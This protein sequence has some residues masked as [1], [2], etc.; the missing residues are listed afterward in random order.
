MRVPGTKEST[1][2]M[3][4][5]ELEECRRS[6]IPFRKILALFLIIVLLATTLLV[7][8]LPD[9][10]SVQTAV[11]KTGI[12]APLTWLAL[13]VISTQFPFPRTVWTVSAGL[14]FGTVLGSALAISGLVVSAAF[15]VL[16]VR[17]LG[18]RT[19]R[20]TSDP[21]MHATL[22][23]I[24]TLLAQRGWVSVLGLRMIPAI[25]FFLVNYACAMTRI[26][27]IPFLGATLIG[28]APNTVATVV[29]TGVLARGGS[30]WVLAVSALVIAIGMVL[31]GREV[32]IFRARVASST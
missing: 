26:P 2:V 1:P 10:Q 3:D 27:L 21:Q 7:V 22:A 8:P 30:P 17:K 15:S 5:K 6:R 14:L 25:P 32:I 28:S 20:R 16:V 18:A 29:V 31:T 11:S 24:Q 19:V 13:M 12:W 4:N 9:A 23:A